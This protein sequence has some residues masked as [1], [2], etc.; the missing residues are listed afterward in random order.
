[1]LTLFFTPD[2][3]TDLASASLSD[4][5]RFATFFHRMLARGVHLPPSQFE[6]LFVSLAHG[7]REIEHTADAARAALSGA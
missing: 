4:T 1:M 2:P 3:V 5:G 6:A 7:E